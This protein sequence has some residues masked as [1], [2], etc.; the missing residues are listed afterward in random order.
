[1]R[2]KHAIF[3]PLALTLVLADCTTKLLA[4]EHLS[5]PHVPHSVIGDVVQFTLAYN[6][7]AAFGVDLLGTSS[8]W[9][10]ALLT[11]VVLSGLARLYHRA[12][13]ADVW[14]VVA[15]ALVCG[16]AVGNLLD[17]LRSP[18][19][20]VDFIDIGVGA[21]RFWTFNVA[22]VGVS[23]GALLLAVALWRREAAADAANAAAGAAPEPG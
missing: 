6:P 2:R 7:G 5:P 13:A 17:R 12:S 4:V 10:L 9:L 3:W 21:T 11:V 23:I 22:D 1:M 8:R 18:R 16:G 14:L 19:G 15:L 20:V